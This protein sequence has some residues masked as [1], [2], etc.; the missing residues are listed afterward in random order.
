MPAARFAPG[1]CEI[2]ETTDDRAWP[3]MLSKEWT[4]IQ[5]YYDYFAGSRELLSEKGKVE[6]GP[7]TIR[8]Q[9]GFHLKPHTIEEMIEKAKGKWHSIQ[10]V[11]KLK[12]VI[13][14]KRMSALYHNCLYLID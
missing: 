9:L 8:E 12:K 5:E 14:A 3:P 2:E 1:Q 11:R 7:N 10:V 4:A 6:E 13:E